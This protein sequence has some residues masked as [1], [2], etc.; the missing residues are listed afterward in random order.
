MSKD[1]S[2][3]DVDAR[4]KSFKIDVNN[5]Q[6]G[7]SGPEMF[8]IIGE[9][10]DGSIFTQSLAAN[11]LLRITNEGTTEIVGGSKNEPDGVDIRIYAS[12]GSITINADKGNLQLK[13]KNIFIETPGT[14]SV[15]AQKIQLGNDMTR[16]VNVQGFDAQLKAQD[17][18]IKTKGGMGLLDTFLNLVGLGD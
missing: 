12:K 18:N 10:P 13:G 8:K 17:T 3:R 14:F 4:S 11:G 5:P 15:L 2:K 16:S 6:E 9:T 7:Q 1:Y